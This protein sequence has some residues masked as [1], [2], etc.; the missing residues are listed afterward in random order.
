MFEMI[1]RTHLIL[2][3]MD[4]QRTD[5]S[6]SNI[7][8]FQINIRNLHLHADEQKNLSPNFATYIVKL[9]V[10][11]IELNDLCLYRAFF[12]Q[13]FVI[14]SESTPKCKISIW[15]FCESTLLFVF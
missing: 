4:S 12:R 5:S 3:L 7:E 10:E 11:F 8:N 13:H 9:S 2:T 6:H 14:F 1:Y 15:V